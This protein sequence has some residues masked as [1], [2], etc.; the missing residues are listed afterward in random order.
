M[1]TSR[2]AP[3][4]T[5]RP[6]SGSCAPR[7]RMNTEIGAMNTL[8]GALPEKRNKGGTQRNP[9]RRGT[10]RGLVHPVRFSCSFRPKYAGSRLAATP[11]WNATSS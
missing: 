1:A 11:A 2:L 5:V 10:L 3:K 4:A 7:H 6:P 8:D 9:G